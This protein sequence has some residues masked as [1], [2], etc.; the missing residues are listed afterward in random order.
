MSRVG[1]NA[2]TK[3]MKQVAGTLRLDLAQYRALAAFAMFASDLDQA[4]QR[5]LARGQ[6]LTEILNQDQFVPISSRGA[7]GL[8]LVGIKRVR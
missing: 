7:G 4:S 1:G 8:D 3:A 5:Q 6:R 2:Q